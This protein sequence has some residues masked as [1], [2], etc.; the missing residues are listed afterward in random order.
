MTLSRVLSTCA[1]FLIASTAGLFAQNKQ[2]ALING[3]IISCDEALKFRDGR[4]AEEIA[5]F[6]AAYDGDKA[7][8]QKAVR[9]R[10]ETHIKRLEEAWT[11]AAPAKRDAI[12]ANGINLALSILGTV[13][14]NKVSSMPQVSANDRAAAKILADRSAA[15]TGMLSSAGLGV[16]VAPADV[17]GLPI[18]V[19]G[20]LGTPVI[21]SAALAYGIGNGLIGVS[22][23]GYDY[24]LD[25]KNYKVELAGFKDSLNRL[26]DKSIDLKLA[27]FM[28][29]KNEIDKKC[30]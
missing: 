6:V 19:V 17:I 4:L 7:G 20:A 22:F 28:R 27:D 13:V 10:F 25:G 2:F 29:V 14:G 21:G 18:A 3:K 1:I 23:A 26:I 12:Y 16:E 8:R 15:L 5:V 24:Y 30:N 9:E 11:K